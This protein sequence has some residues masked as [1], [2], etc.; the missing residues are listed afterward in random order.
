[1][2]KLQIS[3]RK[4]ETTLLL[5]PSYDELISF[6]NQLNGVNPSGCYLQQSGGNLAID[7]SKTNRFLLEFVGLKDGKIRWGMLLDLN[8]NS[9]DEIEIILANGQID[10]YPIQQTIS[11]EMAKYVITYFF[12]NDTI[13]QGLNWE[14]DLSDFG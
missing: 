14:G 3:G 2:R 1:M 7:S 13:P 6:F 12:E 8:A 9:D 10:F 4:M 11:E 5:D